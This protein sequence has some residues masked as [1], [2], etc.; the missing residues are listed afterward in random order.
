M[1]VTVDHRVS[2]GRVLTLVWIV[3][4]AVTVG[5]W[6]LAPGHSSGATASAPVT[7]VVI[8]LGF[9]KGRLIIRHFMEVRSAPRWL[10]ASTDAWLAVLWAAILAIYLVGA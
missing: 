7:L 5:S 1:S 2:T 8:L 10:A 6:W 3:L 4:S 9:L